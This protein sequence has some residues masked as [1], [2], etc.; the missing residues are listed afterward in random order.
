VVEC[1]YCK[2]LDKC[3]LNDMYYNDTFIVK[4]TPDVGG[5]I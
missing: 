3:Q 1:T 4:P 2:S 5:V